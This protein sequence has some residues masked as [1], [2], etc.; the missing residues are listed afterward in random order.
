MAISRLL[1]AGA[2]SV[3]LSGCEAKIG[4]AADNAAETNGA[5]ASAEGKAEEGKFTLDTPGFDLSFNIPMNAAKT[6]KDSRLLYPGSTVT[7]LFIVAG[8]KAPDGSDGEVELRFRSGDAPDRVAAWYRD[9]ARAGEFRIDSSGKEGAE[10]R[11]AGTERKDG[12]G[13]KVRLGPAG[14]GGTDGRLTVRSRD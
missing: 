11:L 10:I 3:L 14:G 7:G 8:P 6:D 4:P 12:Q 5:A 1:A 13:F 9:A 2:V